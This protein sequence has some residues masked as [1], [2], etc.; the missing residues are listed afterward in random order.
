MAKELEQAAVQMEEAVGVSVYC[1]VDSLT[2]P[3]PSAHSIHK[4]AT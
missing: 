4:H 3:S 2:S 1:V